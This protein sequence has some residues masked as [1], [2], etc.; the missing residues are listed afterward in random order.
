MSSLTCEGIFDEQVKSKQSNKSSFVVKSLEKLVEKGYDSPHVKAYSQVKAL[1]ENQPQFLENSFVIQGLSEVLVDESLS[2]FHELISRVLGK[3]NLPANSSSS[4]L[5]TKFKTAL[6][7]ELK[8][9]MSADSASQRVNL[10]SENHINKEKMLRILGHMT[11]EE[12]LVAL[13]GPTGI[14]N[15]TGDSLVKRYLDLALAK[16]ITVSTFVGTFKQGPNHKRRGE[17]KLFVS[18]DRNTISSLEKV[19]G[20]NPHLFMHQH[21]PNQGTLYMRYKGRMNSYAR[22]GSETKFDMSPRGMHDYNNSVNTIIPAMV[23][24][25]VEASNV[26]NYFQLGALENKFAK[27]PWGFKYKD[28]STKEIESYCKAG[29]YSSCTHWI[30]EMPVGEK[31]V[32]SYSV[33]GQ[34]DEHAYGSGD[35]SKELRTQDVG[36]YNYFTS[37]SVTEAIGNTKRPHRL[38]RLVWL[39]GQGHEQLWSVVGD[40]NARALSKGEWAN[41]GW[42]LYS[43][44]SRT[45]QDR[46]P[47]VFIIREDSQAPLNEA[48]LDR[49][50]ARAISPY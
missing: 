36:K 3:M 14:H 37:N 33:P 50:A 22:Y 29:G 45:K 23:L 7:A 48:E 39:E 28:R 24:S 49:I 17:E 4:N 46:V 11:A 21:T 9:I 1:T 18:V 27:Y 35:T 43:F 26:N 41:P 40:K 30:G 25:G 15:L 38:A 32:D 8:K 19:I 42:V 44:L 5:M 12:S 16:G 6:K 2:T 20:A 10:L 13:V 31:L 34:A 47:V